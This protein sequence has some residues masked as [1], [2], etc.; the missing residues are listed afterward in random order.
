MSFS[1]ASSDPTAV[2]VS[3]SSEIRPYTEE[4][5]P[6]SQSGFRP[7]RSTADIAWAHKWLATKAKNED[8][9]IKITG[10]DM[11][12]AFDTT[13]RKTLLDILEHIIEEDEL[14]I[15]RFL[16]SDTTINTRTNVAT[17]E[18][19]FESNIGSP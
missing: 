6:H 1:V 2:I 10:I 3:H 16:L 7:E 15:L 5:L 17:K 19:P 9:E 13:D 4:F 18:I 11:S 8:V 14:R 12:A